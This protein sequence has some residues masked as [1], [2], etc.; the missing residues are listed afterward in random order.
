MMFNEMEF[1]AR[2]SAAAEAGFT[3]V[4]FLFPYDHPK[5]ELAARL[6][7][8][9]LEQVLFNLPPGDWNAGERGVAALPGR[10]SEFRAGLA[11]ALEYAE[12]LGCP[13]L[14][15]MAGVVPKG[16]DLAQCEAVYVDNLRFAARAARSAGVELLIEPINAR[17][18][19]GYFLNRT[20]QACR[21][22]EAVGQDNLFL[23]YDVYHAQI[24][25]GFL[26]ETFRANRDRIRHIQIAGVPGRGEP[27]A[28]QEINYP[29]FFAAIDAAGYDGWFGCEYRPRAGTVEG[30][31]WLAPYLAK[32]ARRKRAAS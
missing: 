11:T 25:E 2:F 16:V 31:G 27:D 26:V 8:A 28:Q 1:L 5:S 6:R 9:G 15:A 19:P 14:H 32:L 29:F 20:D 24:S 12:A 13:R 3:A 22:I 18:M 23:Q 17:D 10:E 4:E 30:L 21:I 7:E